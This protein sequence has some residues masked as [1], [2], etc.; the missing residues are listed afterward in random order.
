MKTVLDFSLSNGLYR[1]G[2]L[3]RSPS[4]LKLLLCFLMSAVR[5]DFLQPKI[6]WGHCLTWVSKF[7]HW[8]TVMDISIT[9]CRQVDDISRRPC[10]SCSYVSWCTAASLIPGRFII[11]MKISVYNLDVLRLKCN[12]LCHC[13][14]QLWQRPL[15]FVQKNP[16]GAFGLGYIFTHTMCATYMCPV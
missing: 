10:L 14:A 6:T 13:R 1:A 5:F 16:Q 7:H 3:Y 15:S 12:G 11:F 4:L 8:Q 9:N 2:R